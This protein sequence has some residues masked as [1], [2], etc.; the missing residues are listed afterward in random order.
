[1]LLLEAVEA[2]A[3]MEQMNEILPHNKQIKTDCTYLRRNV[4]LKLIIFNQQRAKMRT[5][6]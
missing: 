5:I 2:K 3:A 4:I 6:E 1:M